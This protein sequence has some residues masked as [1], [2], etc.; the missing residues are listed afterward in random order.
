MSSS[1]EEFV[2]ATEGS[3][4][5]GMLSSYVIAIIVGG[6]VAAAY[7]FLVLNKKKETGTDTK[8]KTKDVDVDDPVTTNTVSLQDITYIASK[9]NPDS[10][11]L[12]ILMAVASSPE[13][14][15]WG[16]KAH[17]KRQ[18]IVEE[19]KEEDQ[20]E[21]REKKKDSSAN[22]SSS[23]NNSMFELDDEGWADEDEDMQ[24]DE[25]KEKAKLAK[26]A[27][28]EKRMAREELKKVNE[29]PKYVLEGLD[30]GVIGQIW[31]E[32]TL[33][34]SG[35]WPPP[36]MRFLDEMTFEYDGK[37]VSALD[38]P[39]LRRNLCHIAGRTNSIL[40]NSH[41]ELL[42]AAAQQKI[43]QTYF[44]ASQEFRQRCAILLEAALR[45]AIGLRNSKLA[46]T[47]VE[48]VS[49][50]KIGCKSPDQVDWFDGVM[51]KTYGTVPRLSI[52]N[53]SIENPKY[54]EMAAGDTLVIHLDLGRQHAEAFTRQKIA[55][56]QKQGLPP[57]V[58]LQTY[59]E[60]W[61]YFLRGERLDGDV[62]GS[63]L[64]IK[65]D[66]ILSQVD[67]ADVDRFKKA[68]FDERLLIAWPMIV[69]NVAQKS[70]KVKIQFK[71]P[72]VPG[73]YKITVSVK[74]Q[75]FLGADQ[76]F[77]VE[78]DLVDDKTVERK[79]KEVEPKEDD[80]KK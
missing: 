43:D 73:K 25:A 70:G 35:A 68:K 67:S 78:A 52:S 72:P 17:L 12:D 5:N 65:T 26:K 63:V 9:L 31:V 32:S 10:T 33:S 19:R 34:K 75:D 8:R 54:E 44:R 4:N 39:G 38:H 60:G 55:M 15:A 53:V 79:P 27:E 13:S 51:N 77:S 61:W 23:S 30:D 47:I 41:P 56:C 76:E 69:Q 6:L 46:E 29:K 74:S 58:A 80:G 20:K 62:E 40:L 71:A 42:E 16:L 28:E 45:T 7:Y 37:Q 36:D 64:E 66:G 2:E 49:I 1:K 3:G 24:D 22:K 57:Q 18:K 59:H 48:T 21:A 50:F 14:I 11:H